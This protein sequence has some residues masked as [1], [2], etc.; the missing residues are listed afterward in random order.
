[1]KN[2]KNVWGMKGKRRTRKRW[3]RQMA[4]PTTRKALLATLS[5]PS[6]AIFSL[7]TGSKLLS[8]KDTCFDGKE[9][10]L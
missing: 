9:P 1:V 6:E 8:C 2:A 3:R 7:L 5:V 4:D 10:P